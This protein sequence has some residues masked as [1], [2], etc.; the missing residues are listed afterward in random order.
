MTVLHDIEMKSISE[1]K[2]FPIDKSN[3]LKDQ[4]IMFIGTSTAVQWLRLRASAAGGMGLIP[5][6]GNQDP[7]IKKKKKKYVQIES[8]ILKFKDVPLCCMLL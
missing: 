5:G 7:A 1:M 8:F 6:Q 4:K 3:M 2:N